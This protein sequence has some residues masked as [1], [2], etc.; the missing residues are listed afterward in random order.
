MSPWANEPQSWGSVSS[1]PKW[2]SAVVRIPRDSQAFA[3][4]RTQTGTQQAACVVITAVTLLQPQG[5]AT[6]GHHASGAPRSPG[7][8]PVP[9]W[10][11]PGPLPLPRPG[12]RFPH[13]QA[14]TWAKPGSVPAVGQA[15]PSERQQCPQAAQT[16]T[17]SFCRLQGARIQKSR[18][19]IS[20]CSPPETQPH[21]LRPVPSLPALTSGWTHLQ[22]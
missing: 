14:K 11:V 19:Q 12:P 10:P 5:H 2:C 13:S 20:S 3:S 4:G 15:W 22:L 17:T 18:P 9:P 7:P 8:G 16:W 21:P 6:Q 1:S